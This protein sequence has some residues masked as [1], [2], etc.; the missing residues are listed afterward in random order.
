MIL[1]TMLFWYCFDAFT[2]QKSVF[3]ITGMATTAGLVGFGLV[4]LLGEGSTGITEFDLER[5]S[6]NRNS[7]N[8]LSNPTEFGS[9]EVHSFTYG[10]KND[11]RRAEF[12]SGATYQSE[13]VDASLL[14]REW[15]GK[16]KRWRE[17]FWGFGVDQF[18]I[19]GRVHM[20]EGEGPYP[21]ALIVHGNHNM[22]DYSDD[23]YRYL[24]ELLASRGIIAVSV[25]ENFLN[26]HWSGDFR[27]KEMA[28]RAWLLLKHL[29]QWRKW[30]SNPSHGLY[31]KIDLDQVLLIGHSRGG[32][33][34]SIAA[35][36]NELS[37]FPDDA[38]VSFQFNFGIK[39]IVSIAPTD[40]RYDRKISLTDV[41]YLS[42][43]GSYDADEVSFWGM[44]PYR[45][46]SFTEDFN[47]FK[48]GVYIHAA[49]HGQFNQSWGR[50]DFGPPTGWLLNTKPIMKAKDQEDIAKIFIVAFAEAV[51]KN[52]NEYLPLF[53][54]VSTGHNWLP[55][56]YY[57]T[58]F[59]KS[60]DV[61][62]QDFEE[63]IDI[64]HG[65]EGITLHAENTVI[66]REENLSSRN[67]R[68]QDNNA[69]VV[70]WDYREENNQSNPAS[71]TVNIE[72]G[73]IHIPDSNLHFIFELAQ[74]DLS[75]LNRLNDED[76]DQRRGENDE[77]IIDIEIEITDFDGNIYSTLVSHHKNIKPLLHSKF[78][79]LKFLDKEMI[80]DDWE[81]QLESFAIPID[82]QK[83]RLNTTKIRTIR[84]I[85]NQCED[86]I[87]VLDNI[88]FANR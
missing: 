69:V 5:I 51:L 22:I 79:K 54:D 9:N 67:Q 64:T 4:W 26:G 38:N 66:W 14:L 19:N 35:S 49:N 6:S 37:H 25:D 82:I 50:R 30:N 84:F 78:T 81:V 34:V 65:L 39:G 7:M 63:D 56:Q 28:T 47:G 12:A 41:N 46:L 11:I 70:G 43:Q 80:G 45:R 31:Q 3:P 55:A 8:H 29:E 10:S 53:Q 33:A 21:I 32:E 1:S 58:H 52:N 15:K 24:T 87:V 57:L 36:F 18:P 2:R 23:G 74:R 75:E 60:T 88:G 71:Y 48:A 17:Q 20:P 44:R 77:Q 16:K 42:L 27:G 61:F 73:A 83:S 76:P 68:S 40:Y 13:V 62:I 59:S 86:G 72:E 85:F